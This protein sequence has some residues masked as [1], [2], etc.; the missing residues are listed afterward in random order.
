MVAFAPTGSAEF[1]GALARRRLLIVSGKGGVGRSTVA[2][3]LGLELAARGKRVLVATTGHDD[4]LAW[5][6]GHAELRDAPTE[7]REGLFIQRLV[8]TTCVR[9]YGAIMMRSERLSNAVFGNR[10]MKRLIG[11][12]PGLDDYA[13]LGKVWHEATRSGNFDCAVFDGPASGHLRLNLGV[14]R[15]IVETA[16]RGILREEAARIVATLTNPADCAAVLVG[17]PETW[18]LTELRELS[19]ALRDD[20]SV[21]VGAMVV[22]KQWPRAIEPVRPEV[23][24]SADEDF[25]WTHL[26]KLARRSAK[27]AAE[28]DAWIGQSG[29]DPRPMITLP[30]VAGGFDEP[31][32]FDRWRREAQS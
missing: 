4:R 21:D 26:G 15:A 23:E 32:V 3:L 18:P 28:V 27:Q 5:M 14:P 7:V 24:L 11:A 9:E 17:L 25:A 12:V 8:P 1:F 20:L 16:P 2:A 31:A 10:V 30:F 6:L 22:N 19:V 29:G 13:V